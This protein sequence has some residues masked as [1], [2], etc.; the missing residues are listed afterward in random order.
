MNLRYLTGINFTVLFFYTLAAWFIVPQ[1]EKLFEGFGADL[2]LATKLVLQSYRYWWVIPLLMFIQFLVLRFGNVSSAPAQRFFY[3]VNIF[4]VV[5][6]V[7]FV[8]IMVVIF[9][10]PIFSMAGQ[11]AK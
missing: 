2:P 5:L 6:E 8:P 3:V 9:Y 10:L 7:L 11:I 4:F 1:F